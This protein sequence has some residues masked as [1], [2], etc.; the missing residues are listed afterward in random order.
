MLRFALRNS[1]LKLRDPRRHVKD[2]SKQPSPAVTSTHT[3]DLP[4]EH[5]SS[6]KQFVFFALVIT[7]AVNGLQLE[8][9][10][11]ASTVTYGLFSVG[12]QLP[13]RSLTPHTILISPLLPCS[14]RPGAPSVC[15]QC[16]HQ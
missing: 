3:D 12:G 15:S 8:N 10:H 5:F 11:A 4:T 7:K 1:L 9:S 2:I 13:I 6:K 16:S 14:Q